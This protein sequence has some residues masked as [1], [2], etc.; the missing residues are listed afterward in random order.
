VTSVTLTVH[1][2]MPRHHASIR[3][4]VANRTNSRL[5]AVPAGVGDCVSRHNPRRIQRI[6]SDPAITRIMNHGTL[7]WVWDKPGE[8]TE[9]PVKFGASGSG[10]TKSEWPASGIDSPLCI[11]MR[12]GS[13]TDCG[14]GAMTRG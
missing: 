3:N 1:H 7:P 9:V 4:T 13:S 8:V 11:S 6:H 12:R 10:S 2:R 14:S 5:R